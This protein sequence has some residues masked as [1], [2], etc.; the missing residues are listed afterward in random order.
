MR[1]VRAG[2]TTAALVLTTVVGTAA[3]ALAAPPGNDTYAGRTVVGS[4]PFT[5]SLDTTEATTDA[6]DAELNAQCGAPV[7]DASVWYQVTA[8]ADGGMVVDVSQSSFSAGAIVATG[9]PGNWTVVACAP[10]T[11]GW[12]TPIP[13]FSSTQNSGPSVGGLRSSSMTATALVAN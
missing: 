1:L 10:G 12:R 2:V 11:V 8:A 6:D 4:V 7:T 5:Q 13:G 3:P 9:S